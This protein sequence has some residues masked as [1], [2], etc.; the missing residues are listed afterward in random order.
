VPKKI[1]MTVKK[2]LLFAFALILSFAKAQTLNYHKED[3]RL[4]EGFDETKAISELK[5]KGLDPAEYL[6]NEKRLYKV[7]RAKELGIKPSVIANPHPHNA[8]YIN[9]T[10]QITSSCPNSDFSQ[11][12]FT[13]WTGNTWELPLAGTNDWTTVPVWVVGTMGVVNDVLDHGGAGWA[14]ASVPTPNRHVILTTPPTNNNP[15]TGPVIGYD[16]IAINPVTNLADIPLQPPGATTSLRLGNAN[17]GYATTSNAET[18]QIIYSMFVSPSTT[19]FTYQYAVVLNNPGGGHLTNEQPFFEITVKDASGNQIGGPCGRYLVTTDLASDTSY[20]FITQTGNSYNNFCNIYYKNWTTVTIDLSAQMGTNITVEFR[21]ADCSRTGHF[22][23]AYLDAYCGSL[24]GTASG[25]CGGIGT[26]VLNAPPGFSSYQWYGP[27]MGT[28]L[29]PGATAET[30]STSTVA[31]GDTFIV[32]MVSPS[33]CNSSIKIG[34]AGSDIVA[35]YSATP[36]CEGG[37]TGS[38]SAAIAGG[39]NFSYT[40]TN[41]SA[42]VV[43][44]TPNANNLPT[45]TYSVHIVDNTGVCPPKD[46]SV[47]VLV[48]H[49]ALQTTTATLCGTQVLLTA[50]PNAPYTWYNNANVNTGITTQTIVATGSGGEHY[51]CTYKDPATGCLDSLKTSFN[52]ISIGFSASPSP[53]CHGGNNGSIVLTPD[54]ANTY[55]AFD[56]TVNGGGH[57]NGT[58][59]G[60]GP[61]L[62]DS[63]LSGGTYTV[64]IHPTGNTTC[65]FTTSVNVSQAG[66]TVPPPVTVKGC[67]GDTINVV[68]G[69]AP[70]STHH[71]YHNSTP[72]ASPYFNASPLPLSGPLNVNG[73]IYT[74]SVYSAAP[75]FC[76]SVYKVTVKTQSFNAAISQMEAIPCHNDS[77]GSIK[78][79]ATGEVNGPLGHP[80]IFNWTF[81]APYTSPG[82][83]TLGSTPPQSNTQAG[84]HGGIYSVTIRS[85]NCVVTKTLSLVNP[86]PLGKDTLYTFYCPKDD[87]ALIHVTDYGHSPYTWVKNHIVVPGY[88]N[89]SIWVKVGDVGLYQTAYLDHG[90]KDT[91]SVL[92]TF[93][94]WHA[95]VPDTLVNVFT[96]NGDGKN[97]MFYPFY[98]R[99]YNEHDVEKQTDFYN[100]YIYNRWGKLVFQSDSYMNAWTGNDHGE[101]QDDGTYYF[102]VKYKSNCGTKADIITKKGFVQLLR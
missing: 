90:C 89:D 23:Y 9:L 2:L 33:G 71:W 26:A 15:A 21:T 84:L 82:T 4:L 55:T 14:P 44:N 34:I 49:P 68:P 94:S 83:I 30:Y 73:I 60:G 69:V 37:S 42:V 17:I 5:Q 80:Y 36:S 54:S 7:R 8:K 56:W 16:S 10:P 95:L 40:W 79:S 22:G 31:V 29:I 1:I 57:P 43:A 86:A 39:G 88:I 32:K 19:Q 53:A 74:D 102:I 3:P 11:V 67:A 87:S 35:S 41:S 20:H 66:L 28:V 47:K 99:K 24:V 75:N 65:T 12:N 92:V 97:D 48:T 51:T 101:A 38:A 61:M 27:P 6:E 77:T 91:A 25:L 85:G 46:T 76:V 52:Q 72:L 70:G 59:D 18:E 100:I 78:A 96:P 58:P 98:G 45:G 63:L 62:Y 93:P 50:P 64:A 13:N 81:P